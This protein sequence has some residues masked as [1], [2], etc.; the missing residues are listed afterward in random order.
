MSITISGKLDNGQAFSITRVS[1]DKGA[2]TFTE[3]AGVTDDNMS[4]IEGLALGAL[5]IACDNIEQSG[6]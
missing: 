1:K 2:R 3:I 6:K 4:E 5:S